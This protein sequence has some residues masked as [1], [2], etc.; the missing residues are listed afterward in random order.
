M[1]ALIDPSTSSGIPII[2]HKQ[3]TRSWPMSSS[4]GTRTFPP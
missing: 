4:A 3:V 2:L 1:P